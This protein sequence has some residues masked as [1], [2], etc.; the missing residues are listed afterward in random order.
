MA[1]GM[2]PKRTRLGT[3]QEEEGLDFDGSGVVT[4]SLG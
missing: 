3:I 2:G 4:K 1:L